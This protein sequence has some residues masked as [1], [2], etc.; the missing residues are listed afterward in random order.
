[1]K[2]RVVVSGI[3]AGAL[4]IGGFAGTVAAGSAVSEYTFFNCTGPGV[5]STF[6]AVKTLL[7]DSAVHEVSAASAF[8]VVG[9]NAVYVVYDFGFGSNHGVQVSG[10]A[11]DWCWVGFA[12][13]GATLV[14]GVYYGG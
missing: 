2:R 1:M 7:P 10:V 4:A 12:G 8:R 3:L 5:P 13:F 9:S 6:D 14:G 11:T